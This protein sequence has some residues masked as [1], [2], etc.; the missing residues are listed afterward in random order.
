MGNVS[1]FNE[2]FFFV[3]VL[4]LVLVFE[5]V[6]VCEEEESHSSMCE[7]AIKARGQP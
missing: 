7:H 5:C 6:C 4:V 3:S 2:S 1:G